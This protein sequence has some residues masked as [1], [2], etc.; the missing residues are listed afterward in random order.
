LV[1][2]RGVGVAAAPGLYLTQKLDM[3]LDYVLFEPLEKWANSV[4]SAFSSTTSSSSGRLGPDPV[5]PAQQQQQ[6]PQVSSSSS[7]SSSSSAEARVLARSGDLDHPATRVVVRRSLRGL[8]PGPVEVVKRF[9]EPLVLQVS[10][11]GGGG[12]VRG[13]VW[14]APG[15]GDPGEGATGCVQHPSMLHLL[16]HEMGCL[17]ARLYCSVAAWLSYHHHSAWS[18]LRPAH[19]PTKGP[20]CMQRSVVVHKS[21]PKGRHARQRCSK[22]TLTPPRCAAACSIF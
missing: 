2:H 12:G 19:R 16:L 18:A 17:Y 20:S 7:S 4:T 14:V 21:T 8:M 22:K 1:F 9:W 5:K 6:G 11:G 3:L 13:G 15:W 10:T